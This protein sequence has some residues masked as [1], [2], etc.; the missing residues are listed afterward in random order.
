MRFC[1]LS[2]LKSAENY[3]APKRS[4]FYI[5]IYDI[6]IIALCCVDYALLIACNNNTIV[7][8]CAVIVSRFYSVKTENIFA[9]L[10]FE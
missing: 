8:W 10:L 7:K 9:L 1:T 2:F 6:I 5:L 3:P 4:V